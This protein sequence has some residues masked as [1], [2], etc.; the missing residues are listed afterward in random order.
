ME[1]F[2]F[3]EASNIIRNLNAGMMTNTKVVM[4]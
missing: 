1:F 3:L 4:Y 2:V